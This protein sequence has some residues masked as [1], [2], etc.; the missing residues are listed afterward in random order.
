[1]KYSIFVILSLIILQAFLLQHA[2]ATEQNIA[3]H[4]EEGILVWEASKTLGVTYTVY[5]NGE[6][7]NKDIK[8]LSLNIGTNEGLFAVM[9]VL[10][11]T[12]S[13]KAFRLRPYGATNIQ[14]ITTKTVTTTTT[15]IAR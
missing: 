8:G 7:L 4:Q 14:I 2:K 15:K 1:M 10:D 9:A 6:E 11:N 12:K 3:N 5:L 13:S